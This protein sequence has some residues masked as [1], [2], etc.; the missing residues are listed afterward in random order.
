MS[1]LNADIVGTMLARIGFCD[2]LA[3][4]LSGRREKTPDPVEQEQ[5]INMQ[6][7]KQD[8]SLEQ[9]CRPSVTVG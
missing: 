2:V 5:C 6:T 9:L 7:T 4:D 3:V 8:E 1:W